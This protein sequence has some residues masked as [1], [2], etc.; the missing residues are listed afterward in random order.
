MYINV[1]IQ[2]CI[3]CTEGPPPVSLFLVSFCMSIIFLSESLERAST[4]FYRIT[5]FNRWLDVKSCTP[6][7]LYSILA[8]VLLRILD[9]GILQIIACLAVYLLGYNSPVHVPASFATVS[10]ALMVKVL[11]VYGTTPPPL[12]FSLSALLS[13]KPSNRISLSYTS[14]VNYF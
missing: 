4:T 2:I 5:G 8:H 1:P 10:T 11:F 3:L 13:K 6:W 7:V 14:D 12:Q 9:R